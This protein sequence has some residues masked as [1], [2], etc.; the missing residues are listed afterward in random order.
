MRGRS[1]RSGLLE[2]CRHLGEKIRRESPGEVDGGEGG[3]LGGDEE[4]GTAEG[5]GETLTLEE[6]LEATGEGEVKEREGQDHLWV[7]EGN[8]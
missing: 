5:K 2:S 1:R 3:G 8:K 4:V 6:C 7:P